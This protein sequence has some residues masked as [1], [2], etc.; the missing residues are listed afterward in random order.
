LTNNK[1]KSS[2]FAHLDPDLNQESLKR[3][4]GWKPIFGTTS[5]AQGHLRNN[6][7]KEGD[8]F[9]F[10]GLFRDSIYY[11]KRH[12]WLSNSPRRHV[13]WGW[14][15]VDKVIKVDLCDSKKYAWANYHPHFGRELDSNNTIYIGKDTLELP[16][17]GP[18]KLAGSGVFNKFSNHLVL[19][20]SNSK[21]PLLWEL[22]D[23][24]YPYKNKT[25]L[26]YHSDLSRWKK[27]NQSTLL[28]LV[29]RGQEFILNVDEY[30]EAIGWLKG[31]LSGE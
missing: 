24:F 16:G 2:D 26:T 12:L 10:F 13:L 21:S 11:N 15:Q 17:Q 9:L 29:A 7:V 23:W 20:A 5:A 14:L 6:G 8:I 28:N 27:K 25:P 1:I 19:T 18:E 3:L 22:P 31:I 30:P 4:P